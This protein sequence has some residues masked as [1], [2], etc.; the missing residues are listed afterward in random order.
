MFRPTSDAKPFEFYEDRGPKSSKTDMQNVKRKDMR[1]DVR[2][3]S[4]SDGLFAVHKHNSLTS[5]EHHPDASSSEIPRH[6][7][8]KEAGLKEE[9]GGCR[10]PA[11][12]KSPPKIDNA[13]R[14]LLEQGANKSTVAIVEVCISILSFGIK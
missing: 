1:E 12:L 6:N 4:V 2:R 3:E 10:R 13:A 5:H 7:S 9:M 11:L 8:S 14:S